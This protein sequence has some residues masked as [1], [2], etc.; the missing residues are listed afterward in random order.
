MCGVH[1]C[2]QDVAPLMPVEPESTK[3]RNRQAKLLEELNAINKKIEKK[4]TQATRV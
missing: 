2:D 3:G 1:M 4:R